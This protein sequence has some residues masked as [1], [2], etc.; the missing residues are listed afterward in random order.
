MKTQFS[1]LIEQYSIWLRDRITIADINGICEITTPF[2]DRHNDRLQIYVESRSSGLRLTDDGYIIGDL[3]AS[4]CNLESPSRKKILD[5]IIN[6]Y[7]VS[8][9]D[10]EIYVEAQESDFPRKKHLLIQAMLSVNDLFF[11]SKAKVASLFSEDV[12]K[13]LE[14]NDVRYTENISFTGKSG[15][16][17]KFDYV[18]PKSREKP[19]RVIKAINNP[20]RETASSLLFAWTDTKETRPLDSQMYAILNDEERSISPEITTSLEYYMIKP[21]PWSQRDKYARELAA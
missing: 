17:H 8:L 10:G 16:A 6:G 19:E 14:D 11:L 13:Y 1:K 12:R 20:S 21:I 18:I 3:L 9:K 4:G 15:F 7:G 2:L 5:T